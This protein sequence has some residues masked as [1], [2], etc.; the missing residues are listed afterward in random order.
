MLLAGM[1]AFTILTA[2]CG[3]AWG[4]WPLIAFRFLAGVAAALA[5]PQI[6]ASIPQLVPGDRIVQTMGRWGERRSLTIGILV[7]TVGYI[8]IAFT[9]VMIPAVTL[10]AIIMLAGGFVFPVMMAALQ[11]RAGAARG[12]MSSLANVA[13]YGGTTIGAAIAGPVFAATTGFTGVAIL[14]IITYLLALALFGRA[15]R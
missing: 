8:A 10:L 14:A 3:L 7:M 4:F 1:A 9:R 5:T 2:A 12:T 6:W 13:I 15:R 11:S